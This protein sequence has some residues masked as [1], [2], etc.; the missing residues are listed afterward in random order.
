LRLAANDFGIE[1]EMSAQIYRRNL[2]IYELDISYYRRSYTEGKKVNWQDGS[3]AL[4]FVFK[5]RFKSR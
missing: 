4:W 2:R 3:K 1:I 5:F